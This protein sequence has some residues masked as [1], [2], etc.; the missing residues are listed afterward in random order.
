MTNKNELADTW[1]TST[2]LGAF[3]A[4]LIY[5]GLIF[6]IDRVKPHLLWLD[7]WTRLGLVFPRRFQVPG[8]KNAA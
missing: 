7:H 5:L 8:P 3:F 2:I 4:W 6:L 1:V